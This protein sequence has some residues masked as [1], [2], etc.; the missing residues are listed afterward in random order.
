MILY[1]KSTV[2]FTER[3]PGSV[4]FVSLFPALHRIRV[5]ELSVCVLIRRGGIILIMVPCCIPVVH[6]FKQIDVIRALSVQPDAELSVDLD[7]CHLGDP[8]VLWRSGSGFILCDSHICRARWK[9]ERKSKH[10]KSV[11]A[12]I[13]TEA[14]FRFP[15]ILTWYRCFC[16]GI[17]HDTMLEK[18]AYLI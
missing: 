11:Q 9:T 18:S 10:K 17:A 4:L 2:W 8:I 13:S 7:R 3:K 5:I 16:H 6:H 1:R 15:M 12:G 14:R